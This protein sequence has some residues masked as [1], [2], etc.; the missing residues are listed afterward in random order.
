[1]FRP[2]KGELLIVD[3]ADEF[4]LMKPKEFI[5]M[6]QDCACICFTA[7]PTDGNPRGSEA[8]LLDNIGFKIFRYSI[9]EEGAKQQ[10][11]KFDEEV[12]ARS[13]ELK[14]KEILKYLDDGSVLVFCNDNLKEQLARVY[15]NIVIVVEGC[16]QAVLRNLN[17]KPHKLVISTTAF[18]RRGID[19]RSENS[20]LTLVVA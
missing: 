20:L 17:L 9:Q 4:I 14:V 13:D 15:E 5:R 16:D 1:M 11:L 19:Y 18:G 3:E 12:D 7:T 6:I 8:K 2:K 10:D